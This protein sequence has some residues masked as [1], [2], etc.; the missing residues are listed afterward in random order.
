[1]IFRSLCHL[2]GLKLLPFWEIGNIDGGF[3]IKN[4]GK[5]NHIKEFG[6]KR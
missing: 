5:N 6:G 1:M 4:L 3:H 2:R